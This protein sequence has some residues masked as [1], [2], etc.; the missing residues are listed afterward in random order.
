MISYQNPKACLGF[1]DLLH[2]FV[3]CFKIRG[4]IKLNNDLDI[5]RHLIQ[6]TWSKLSS[7]YMGEVLFRN[8]T[9]NAFKNSAYVLSE[10]FYGIEKYCSVAEVWPVKVNTYTLFFPRIL[11]NFG[12]KPKFLRL[13][14][15]LFWRLITAGIP[16][17][18]KLSDFIVY[19]NFVLDISWFS[20]FG[21]ERGP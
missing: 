7:A 10:T 3:S 9:S 5:W 19:T 11:G 6:S 16:Y 2:F 1:Q 18:A 8:K 17:L 12:Q 14:I 4:K 21:P 15:L 20:F 13:E